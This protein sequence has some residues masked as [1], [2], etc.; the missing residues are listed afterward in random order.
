ML[1]WTLEVGNLALSA[2]RF[3]LQ[4]HQRVCKI[5]MNS[6]PF[7]I[8]TK[9]IRPFYYILD[10]VRMVI[11][12]SHILNP[13][14]KVSLKREKGSK[15]SG[16][17]L[18][19]TMLLLIKLTGICPV[20]IQNCTSVYQIY[21]YMCYKAV[22]ETRVSQPVTCRGVVNMQIVSLWPREGHQHA[23]NDIH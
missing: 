7:S 11:L 6:F 17:H 13:K 15:P 16:F 14:E 8:Q 22:S 3:C 19:Y 4:V 10:D 20:N 2:L 23:I 12:A 5:L 1:L 9:L 21:G 18:T